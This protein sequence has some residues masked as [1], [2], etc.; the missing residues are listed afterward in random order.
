MKP[1]DYINK[2][3]AEEALKAYQGTQLNNNQET[4]PFFVGKI[5]ADRTK[6]TDPADG[7]QYDLIFTGNPKEFELAQ[8]LSDNKAVVNAAPGKTINVDG[9]NGL[10]LTAG[11]SPVEGTFNQ[12]QEFFVFNLDSSKRYVVSS[13]FYP[14]TVS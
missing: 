3:A 12:F 8:K 10:A 6:I 14:S 5:N 2:K 9:D 11:W 1:K 7:R 13:D 4:S